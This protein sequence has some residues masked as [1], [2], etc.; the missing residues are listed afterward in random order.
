MG[1]EDQLKSKINE[2]IKKYMDR[3]KPEFIPGK[4]KIPLQVA[5]YGSDEVCEA[6]DSMLS[7]WVTM[8]K[9]VANFEQLFAKY[10]GIKNATMVNSGSS[11]NLVALSILTNPV[12]RDKIRAGS[13]IITPATT[14]TT[15]VYPI[16]NVNCKPVLVDVDLDTFN[17][18]IEGIEKAI[19]DKT[20]AIMPVHLLGN[21]CY[22]EE[23]MEIAEKHDLYVIE[24]TCESHGAEVKGKKVGTFG[25]MG[26]FSFFF[27]HHISTIEG[28]MIVT[29]E[30]EYD[31]LSRALRVFGWARNMKRFEEYAQNH[32]DIDK[33][34]LFVNIGFNFRPTEIQGAFGTH[35]VKKLDNFIEIRRKN[36]SY[37]NKKLEPYTDYITTQKERPKTRH[38]WFG[39]PLTINRES[40]FTRDEITSHLEKKGIETRPIQVPNIA[41]QPA[42]K[43]I[44]YRAVGGLNNADYIMKNSFWFG[45]HQGIGDAE[46]KYVADAII[47]FVEEKV[48]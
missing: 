16:A 29:N 1:S 37:W 18:S 30:E 46:R 21:P 11:A 32:K 39:Y 2:L 33:R 22:I 45:N 20:K 44:D 31:E 6:L 13:E 35:Q 5:S 25:D 7:T 48:K 15:T 42:I 43:L 34:F 40:P 26:T 17:I 4:S 41:K 14:W 3:G 24:D 23:I 47:D 9:K 19:T 38:V 8:G 10:L 12:L 28:G 27:S 36:A